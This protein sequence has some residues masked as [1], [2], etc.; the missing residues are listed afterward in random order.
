MECIINHVQN[1]ERKYLGPANIRRMRVK[2][3]T[4]KGDSLDLNG[5]NWSFSL[6][7]KI[8]HKMKKG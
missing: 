6:S 3:I 1:N 7:C 5:S 4:D 8:L 2:L